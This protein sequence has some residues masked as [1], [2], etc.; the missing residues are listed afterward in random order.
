MTKQTILVINCGSSSLKFALI[1]VATKEESLSGLAQRLGSEQASITIKYKGDKQTMALTAPYLHQAA[2]AKLIEFLKTNSLTDSIVAIGHRV[3]HG[4]EEYHLPTLIT[5]KVMA[6]LKKLSNLA[7]LHNP[8]NIIG[9]EAALAAFEHLPQVAVFDTAFH[10][11]IPNK[12]FLYAV[13]QKLYKE[14]SIRKYGFHGTSHYFVSR[15]AANMLGKDINELSLVTVHLGNGCSLAA[16]EAG[17]SVDTSMG[18]T[19]LAGVTMGTRSGDID[20]GVIF[21]LTSHCGY[22][23]EQVDAMLNKESGLLGLSGIS[24]DCRTLEEQALEENNPQAKLALDVFSFTIAKSL[25]AM[26]VSLSKLDGIVFTGGIGEN[27]DYVRDQVIKQLSVLGLSLNEALNAQAIRGKSLN[28]ATE[29]S[30]AILVVPTNEEW[31]IANQTHQ[32]IQE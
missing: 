12:A 19:P 6:Q 20:P 25:A 9:I 4:G 2:L 10:Q 3:V 32:L 5:E 16:I 24:N 11:S 8:A 22:T 13:P 23:V 7:P 26:T 18:F 27:S 1:D 29:Q 15:E 31:V 17:Q 14:H 21:H 30:P 28:I